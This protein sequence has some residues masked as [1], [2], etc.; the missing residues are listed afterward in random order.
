[1]P[2]RSG[3]NYSMIEA[4]TPAPRVG[5]LRAAQAAPRSKKSAFPKKRALSASFASPSTA[6]AELRPQIGRVR[7]PEQKK[8]KEG[9]RERDDASL[10][11][12]IQ[13]DKNIKIIETTI[14]APKASP[15]KLPALSPTPVAAPQINVLLAR[16]AGDDVDTEYGSYPNMRADQMQTGIDLRDNRGSRYE[17]PSSLPQI[18]GGTHAGSPYLHGHNTTKQLP[19]SIYRRHR[20]ESHGKDSTRPPSPCVM[21][22]PREAVEYLSIHQ[23]D[24]Y[25][26]PVFPR[27]H[28]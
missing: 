10:S 21:F 17:R 27:G 4:T 26:P 14:E 20:G 8:A 16:F 19:T 5:R 28:H 25:P 7:K 18:N 2:T 22:T 23:P 24:M 11:K 9:S 13:N 1:M 6:N 12:L 15:A 3:K